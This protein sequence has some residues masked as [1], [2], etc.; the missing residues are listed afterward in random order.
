MLS[1]TKSVTAFV[2]EFA[3]RNGDFCRRKRSLTKI[4]QVF[5]AFADKV[6]YNVG[7][8]YARTEN[9]GVAMSLGNRIQYYRKQHNLSQEELGAR[10]FVSRQTVSQWETGQTAPSL[11]SLIRLH[12]LF[13]VS[14]DV[15]LGT[16]EPS[17]PPSEA[18]PPESS[19]VAAYTCRHSVE[20][21]RAVM[22]LQ[23]RP[24]VRA[25][26]GNG[27]FAVLL[28]LVCISAE[29]GLAVLLGMGSGACLAHAVLAARTLSRLSRLAKTAAEEIPMRTYVYTLTEELL[30]IDIYEGDRHI[31]RDLRPLSAVE[32]V[33]ETEKHLLIQL[34]NR[35]YILN[36]ADV[37]AYAELTVRLRQNP[38]HRE[39]A[40]R[41]MRRW[42]SLGTLA[43]VLS[44]VSLPVGFFL[45]GII[46][47]ITG[48]ELYAHMWIIFLFLPI[49]LG[50]LVLGVLLKKR[51]LKYKKNL[52]IGIIMSLLLIVYGS[53]AAL[54]EGMDQALTIVEHEMGITLPEREYFSVST[55]VLPKDP[56]RMKKLSLCELRFSEENGEAFY[57]AMDE[58]WLET[59]PAEL[60]A[61]AAK[62]GTDFG[63]EHVLLYNVGTGTYN[64]PPTEE[65]THEIILMYVSE[66]ADTVYILHYRL[67]I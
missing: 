20:E 27:L 30:R 37:P 17:P 8:S 42:K 36:K 28:F 54:F 51:G 33:T 40:S 13:G 49:P 9:G 43:F 5:L 4:K 55:S 29:A 56:T 2:H 16:D 26:I 66:E 39:M 60:A 1:P 11:D 45:S 46:A 7:R 15:L 14:V 62:D 6:C 48:A 57:A 44:C 38:K 31:G 18:S 63:A 25:L 53:F 35:L 50:S 58:R 12:D 32:E 64:T 24:F 59:L 47:S 21:V 52:I 67:L 19:R 3:R 61:I 34:Q 22:S 23:K 41:P 10:L 65:G